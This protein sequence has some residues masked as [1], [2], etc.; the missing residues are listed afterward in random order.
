MFSDYSR[1]QMRRLIF[2]RGFT[3]DLLKIFMEAGEI[4][5]ARC[6]ANLF[7]AKPVFDQ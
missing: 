5:K 1:V 2:F 4:I 3:G 7:Q 6:K